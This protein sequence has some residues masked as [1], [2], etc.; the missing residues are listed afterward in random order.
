MTEASK[1]AVRQFARGGKR[2][3]DPATPTDQATPWQP[4]VDPSSKDAGDEK[5]AAQQYDGIY[6][7]QYSTGSGGS[8]SSS[9]PGYAYMGPALSMAWTTPPDLIATKETA[10]PSSPQQTTDV[11]QG[12]TISF[13]SLLAGEQGCL[14][15]TQSAVDCYQVLADA[16]NSAIG[17]PNIFGQNVGTMGYQGGNVPTGPKNSNSI[18]D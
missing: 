9:T 15:A 1:S 3:I 8:G 6:G 7:G 18:N 4:N 2:M 16:V 14:N 10:D 13:Q 17:D 11:Y 12:F 5:K